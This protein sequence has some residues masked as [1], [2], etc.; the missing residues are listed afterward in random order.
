MQKVMITGIAGGFGMPTARALLEQGYQVA[1]SVRHRA[2]KNAK[3]VEALEAAGKSLDKVLSVFF[4]VA[5]A[6]SNPKR[7]ELQRAFSPELAAHFAEISS[8]KALFSRLASL[9][10]ARDDLDLTP[11]Q[12]RVL[13]AACAF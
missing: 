11:E 6:D 1:G 4:S 2:G 5:G 8:N 7:E 10:S 3:T 9:W 13:H 12:A